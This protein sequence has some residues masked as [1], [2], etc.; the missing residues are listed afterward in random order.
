MVK[1]LFHSKVFVF[2]LSMVIF[3]FL[4]GYLYSIFTAKNPV[5]RHID[6]SEQLVKDY[7]ADD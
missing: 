3:G 2:F 4:L 6:A 5:G 7:E 1:R